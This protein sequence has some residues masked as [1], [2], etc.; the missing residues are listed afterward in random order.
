MSELR[1]RGVT[2]FAS[3]EMRDVFG[4]EVS[5][6]TPDLSSI[7]DNLMLMRFFETQSEL[8]RLLSILKVRD[9]CYDPSL[10]EVV[11]H[12]HGV[13]LKK[14]SRHATAVPNDSALPRSIS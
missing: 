6:P 11:I 5:A 10:L 8:R 7:V 4:S 1:A 13:E 9:S 12:E 3:W 14:A 2:V